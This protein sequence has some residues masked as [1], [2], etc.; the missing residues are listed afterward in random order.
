MYQEKRPPGLEPLDEPGQA[1]VPGIREWPSLQLR[2]QGWVPGSAALPTR[3]RPATQP[4]PGPGLCG[5]PCSLAQPRLHMPSAARRLV[6]LLPLRPARPWLSSGPSSSGGFRW[7]A[8][9]TASFTPTPQPSATCPHPLPSALPGPRARGLASGQGWA[10]VLAARPPGPGNRE[11][12]PSKLCL[13]MSVSLLLPGPPPLLL[14]IKQGI[15]FALP[16]AWGCKQP[17]QTTSCA[18]PGLFEVGGCSGRPQCFLLLLQ[19]QG[20][21]WPGRRETLQLPHWEGASTSPTGAEAT[22]RALGARDL[23]P[24][25]SLNSGE[26]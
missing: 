4:S 16:C 15:Y 10:G 2:L 12:K 19:E 26:L 18:G 1:W 17:L 7:V 9:P 14:I 20:R 5:C 8:G 13:P 3:P 23:C 25:T 24:L 21:G 22:D 6:V 11:G